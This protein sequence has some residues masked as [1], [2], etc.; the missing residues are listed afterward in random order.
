MHPYCLLIF[1][2]E[3][4]RGQS[5]KGNLS[6]LPFRMFNSCWP[7]RTPALEIFTL[8]LKGYLSMPS[9][10][11]WSLITD[12]WFINEKWSENGSTSCRTAPNAN[13][14]A[15]GVRGCCFDTGVSIPEAISNQV[16]HPHHGRSVPALDHTNRDHGLRGAS[17]AEMAIS[18][19]DKEV[20]ILIAHQE[21]TNAARQQ[22]HLSSRNR[23]NNNQRQQ[24]SN[25]WIDMNFGWRTDPCWGSLP[26]TKTTKSRSPGW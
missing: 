23:Q 4:F 18:K 24:N 12:H 25:G 1:Q 7:L 13:R 11:W 8:M 20:H 16:T 19:E 2:V 9:Y 22:L 6:G 5:W 3:H 10:G 26:T 15:L 17:D 21:K 14:S